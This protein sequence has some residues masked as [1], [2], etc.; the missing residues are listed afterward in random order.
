M[1]HWG[2]RFVCVNTNSWALECMAE[3]PRGV[4][5][6]DAWLVARR[7]IGGSDTCDGKRC[8]SLHSHCQHSSGMEMGGGV[9]GRG[10]ASGLRGQ[11]TRCHTHTVGHDEDGQE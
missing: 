7:E 6:H 4:Y 8:A 1:K 11:C 5:L 9:S 2:C 3:Q 10:C